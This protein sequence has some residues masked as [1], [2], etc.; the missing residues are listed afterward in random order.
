MNKS[1]QNIIVLLLVALFLLASD[2]KP[3]VPPLVADGEVFN[4]RAVEKIAGGYYPL[5]QGNIGTCVAV[6]HKGAVDGSQAV[7]VALGK[8][9]VWKPVSAESIYGGARNEG[10]GKIFHSR[11][12]GSSG[13]AATRWLNNYGVTYM[14]VYSVKDKNGRE[15]TIDLSSY[16]IPRAKLWGAEG[17]G[18]PEDGFN[19]PFDTEA[20]KH[21]VQMTAK[22][23]SLKELDAALDNGYITSHCSNIGFD[24]PRDKDGFC[25]RRGSWSHCMICIGR[26]DGGRKGYLIQN[27]WGAYI[28]G[29]A[30]DSNKYKDQPDG[31]FYIEPRDMEAILRQGDSY[32]I[33]T[34]KGFEKRVLPEWLT[35]AD[36]QAP[37]EL[38]AL[39]EDVADDS[40]PIEQIYHGV[41]GQYHYVEKNGT[42]WVWKKARCTLKGC[43]YEWVKEPIKVLV[44]E[45][46]H[47]LAA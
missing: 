17:N 44:E 35:S 22:V 14:Q 16:D 28:R 45:T 18:G 13:Y 42:H 6:G 26:R 34:Q 39:T 46:R 11:M 5:N 10:R 43:T 9:K 24:S 41:D 21:P 40:A 27:S 29:D 1:L 15:R 20:Q 19:G 37:A 25:S 31:S 4:Y 8:E 47:D 30:N 12:D 3:D 36:A 7:A 2:R 32:A 23:T 33:G 38:V